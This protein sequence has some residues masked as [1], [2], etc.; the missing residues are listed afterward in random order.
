MKKFLDCKLYLIN[1]NSE[2]IEPFSVN[3]DSHQTT[4]SSNKL[5]ICLAN[6]CTVIYVFDSVY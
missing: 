6:F 2:N 4:N 1:K 3:I 5:L